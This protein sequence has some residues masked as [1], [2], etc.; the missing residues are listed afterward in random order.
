[1]PWQTPKRQWWLPHEVPHPRLSRGAAPESPSETSLSWAE[2]LTYKCAPRSEGVG[3]FTC[4]VTSIQI[5]LYVRPFTLETPLMFWLVL[6]ICS[7]EDRAYQKG[8]SALNAEQHF[9]L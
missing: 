9:D 5:V 7:E 2:L 4:F 8:I 1:M 6:L 3:V